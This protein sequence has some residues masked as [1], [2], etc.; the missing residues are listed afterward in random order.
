MNIHIPTVNFIAVTTVDCS[1]CQPELQGMLRMT[2]EAWHNSWWFK[3][4]FLSHT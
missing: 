3:D 2:I 4:Y 1:G